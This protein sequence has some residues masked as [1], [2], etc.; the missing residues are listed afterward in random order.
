MI[1]GGR[2]P[3]A[4]AAEAANRALHG[5]TWARDQLAAHAGRVVAVVSGPLAAAFTIQDDGTFSAAPAGAVA[6]LTLT[7]SPLALPA[8]A[9]EP[10]RWRESVRADG[11]QALAATLESIAQTFAWFVERA[12][13][14]VFG[15]IAG[16]AIADAGRTL[17]SI[18][19][20]MSHQ[21]AAGVAQ[22]ASE[23][24]VVAHRGDFAAFSC[25]TVEAEERV[26]ALAARIAA[27]EEGGAPLRKRAKKVT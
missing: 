14:R 21:A 23:A 13:A 24:D 11:D 26:A 6:D 19:A 18:P 8:L 20:A 16:Q 10:S 9:A 7:V 22:F 12:F 27:L 17:L 25:G 15:P 5:E 4:L 2:S 1:L 3:E